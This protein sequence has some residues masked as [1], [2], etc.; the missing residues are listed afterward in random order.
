MLIYDLAIVEDMGRYWEVTGVTKNNF[1]VMSDGQNKHLKL[2]SMA[3]EK[4]KQALTQG[5]KCRVGKPLPTNEVLPDDV[6]IIT[7][8][9]SDIQFSREA[10]FVRA[11]MHVTPEMAKHSGYELYNFMCKNNELASKGYFITDNNREDQYIKI[12]ETADDNLINLLESYLE[13][14]D[15]IQRGFHISA[16]LDE[17][18]Q[19]LNRAE[20]EEEITKLEEDLIANIFNV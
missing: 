9:T 18:N 3:Y 16:K 10:A 5:Q 14:K 4:I 20:T 15:K 17:F 1:D 11:K 12:I 2:S 6:Q 8:D 13:S 19:N 7:N